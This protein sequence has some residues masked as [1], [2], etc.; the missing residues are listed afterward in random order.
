MVSSLHQT[1]DK[2]SILSQEHGKNSG[3]Y[4]SW[5]LNPQEDFKKKKVFFSI[6]FTTGIN[7]NYCTDK[8]IKKSNYM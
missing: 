2:D 3:L 4:V 7:Y 5:K 6:L 1:S 8:I